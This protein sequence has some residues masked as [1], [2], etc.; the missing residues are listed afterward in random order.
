MDES[1]SD[2]RAWV[3]DTRLH[4]RAPS[5]RR[6][7]ALRWILNEAER[8][9]LDSCCSERQRGRF[10]G[11]SRRHTSSVGSC[12]ATHVARPRGLAEAVGG[13]V[14]SYVTWCWD[15]CMPL[16]V[17][18]CQ[19]FAVESTDRAQPSALA[20]DRTTDRPA[21][22]RCVRHRSTT[23]RPP[24]RPALSAARVSLAGRDGE[25][26]A[27]LWCPSR[28]LSLCLSVCPGLVWRFCPDQRYYSACSRIISAD[29]C[30]ST[31]S[32]LRLKSAIVDSDVCL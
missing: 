32:Q 24:A 29:L 23:R 28:R 13:C 27:S 2:K 5:V 19:S 14:R 22:S 31:A 25:R 3:V 26:P 4:A 8:K 10:A 9:A 1:V 20:H 17:A 11:C 15:P 7:T 30:S 6:L 12:G 16:I 18:H 21:A